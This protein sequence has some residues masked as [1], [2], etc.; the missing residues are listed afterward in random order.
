[1]KACIVG[2]SFATHFK[3]T[4]LEILFNNLNLECVYCKG[5]LGGCEFYSYENFL[6]ALERN[7]IELAI[8]FHTHQDRIPN[9]DRLGITHATASNIS[10]FSNMQQNQIN[11]I[12]AI[13]QYYNHLFYNNLHDWVHYTLIKEM[14]QT[15]FDKNIKQ[16]HLNCF[17]AKDDHIMNYGLWISGGLYSLSS[18]ENQDFNV[19]ILK[20]T[21][22]NHFSL[23]LHRKFASWITP[24]ISEYLNYGPDLKIVKLDIDSINNQ[25]I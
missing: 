10:N 3:E 19:T 2:D 17:G 14:E 9:S 7:N 23:N 16:I 1:M 4:W 15:C 5:E 6:T 13:N 21:R 22:K 25:P 24:I 12:K 18:Q 8:F 20:D 11:L